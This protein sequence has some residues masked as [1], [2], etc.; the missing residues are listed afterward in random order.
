LLLL[1]RIT[2]I[3]G[4]PEQ[5]LEYLNDPT[6][7]PESAPAKGEWQLWRFKLSLLESAQKWQELFETTKSLLGR[8]RTKDASGQLSES[9]M[10]DWIVWEAF[11]RS[12]VELRNHE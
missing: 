7:G 5:R 10:S 12:A 6:L 1:H 8:V 9:G 4:K 3:L 2:E 11:I